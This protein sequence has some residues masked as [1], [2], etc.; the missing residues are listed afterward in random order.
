MGDAQ[1]KA[2][3]TLWQGLQITVRTQL[4]LIGSFTLISISNY[5]GCLLKDILHQDES[6]TQKW[7]NGP[8]EQV[9]QEKR[10]GE[11]PQM[12]VLKA[13]WTLNGS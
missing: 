12:V 11:Y 1:G 4:A 6:E 8:R 5:R 10:L 13:W 9:I 7:E 3:T 2:K